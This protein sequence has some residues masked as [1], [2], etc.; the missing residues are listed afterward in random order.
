MTHAPHDPHEAELRGIIAD[1]EALEPLSRIRPHAFLEG[2]DAL[3]RR[4]R[5][6]YD[7]LRGA[8]TSPATR[9]PKRSSAFRPGQIARYGRII[10]VERRGAR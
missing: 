3:V 7:D 5:D 9:M 2:K 4:L 1:A 10:P 6:F 8:P